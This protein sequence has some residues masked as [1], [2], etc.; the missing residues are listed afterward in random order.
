MELWMINVI[1]G[2][3]EKRETS[4][5][6]FC[7]PKTR[8]SNALFC[9]GEECTTKS[10]GRTLGRGLK[11]RENSGKKFKSWVEVNCRGKCKRS[12]LISEGVGAVKTCQKFGEFFEK[13]EEN[14]RWK[15]KKNQDRLGTGKPVKIR[16]N[17]WEIRTK[18]VVQWIYFFK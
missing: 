6:G 5:C 2:R 15:C 11:T 9:T 8:P 16:G 12:G 7:K 14:Y 13:V 18:K 1:R 4:F 10:S 17:F 3:E